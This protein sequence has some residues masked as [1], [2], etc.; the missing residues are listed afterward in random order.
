MN[1]T[2]NSLEE[3]NIQGLQPSTKYQ[4]RVVAYNEHG[5][6]D[7]SDEFTVETQGE[8]KDIVYTQHYQPN[9]WQCTYSL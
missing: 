4:F 5:P 1:T 6:G 9:S 3:I 2:R 7:S 8:G